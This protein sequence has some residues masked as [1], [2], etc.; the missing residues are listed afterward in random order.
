MS[1]H[2]AGATEVLDIRHALEHVAETAHALCGDDTEAAD[3][4][5]DTCRTKLLTEDWAATARQIVVGRKIFTK[6]SHR[7]SLNSLSTHLDNN[8]QRLGYIG[9]LVDGHSIGSGQVEGACKHLVGRGLKQTGARWRVRRVN[10]MASPC[11]LLYSD[12]WDAY[13]TAS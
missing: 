3:A 11:S 9:R 12:H 6:A 1:I 7:E 13:S 8:S 4:W 10:R 5:L 2:S